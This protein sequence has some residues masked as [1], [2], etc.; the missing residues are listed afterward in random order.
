MDKEA[1]SY[2]QSFILQSLRIFLRSNAENFL[3]LGRKNRSGILQR[4]IIPSGS[5]NALIR[6]IYTPKLTLLERRR[7][8]QNLF[9]ARFGL[10]ERA[11]TFE[12]PDVHSHSFPLRGDV[13]SA[14]LR[15]S[16]EVIVRHVREVTGGR[17]FGRIAKMVLNFKVDASERLWLLWSSSI[18][19]EVSAGIADGEFK[20][21][22]EISC[23]GTRPLN[24]DPMVKLMGTIQL[25]QMPNHS[26][27]KV[28]QNR[29]VFLDC[30]SCGKQE[31]ESLFHPVYYKTII[32]HF[33]KVKNL[34]TL[35]NGTQQ[36]LEWPPDLELIIAAGG[37]G[38]ACYPFSMCTQNTTRVL[39]Q[40][41]III[42][43]LIRHLHK[44]LNAEGFDR[45]KRDPIFLHKACHVCESCFLAYAKLTSNSFQVMRPISVDDER[46]IA[47][48]RREER[49]KQ[50]DSRCLSIEEENYHRDKKTKKLHHS[51]TNKW[52][53][54]S[55]KSSK[56]KATQ[57]SI[58]R[59]FSDAPRLP[60]AEV[61]VFDANNPTP[62]TLVEK[63][64]RKQQEKMFLDMASLGER[65][66]R[67]NPLHHL[68]VSHSNL[69]KAA[70]R[71]SKPKQENN[72][73]NPYQ[74]VMTVIE[75]RIV[76]DEHR[77]RR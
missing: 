36:T 72:K 63:V 7:N 13:L 2:K 69:E 44:R 16:C 31:T 33:E 27:D 5:R 15:A 3:S 51:Y 57:K 11:I 4:F 22:S 66:S 43:P 26:T 53:L 34:M 65:E 32:A 19:M 70:K 64:I 68:I 58:G 62:P 49:S 59:M 9:D 28:V 18:R 29:V 48:R 46:E 1:L 67:E 41:D 25:E 76:Q 21:A 24:I 50:T 56:I 20:L 60:C 52:N 40:E 6:A 37:V 61:Y 47:T 38:F 75:D 30:L 54:A 8:N 14:K 10:Y 35:T 17:K 42:P 73:K 55:K 39:E 77:Q 45:Y 23:D 71:K 12:G 74:E